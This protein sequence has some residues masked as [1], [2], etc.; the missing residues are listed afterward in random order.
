MI[1]VEVSLEVLLN[2]DEGEEVDDGRKE[3]RDFEVI[4]TV[5]VNNGRVYDVEDTTVVTKVVLTEDDIL[6]LD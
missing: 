5:V 3:E 1:G 2:E 4:T 6:L